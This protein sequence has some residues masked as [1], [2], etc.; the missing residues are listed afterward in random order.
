MLALDTNTIICFFKAQGRVAQRLAQANPDDLAIP[1]VVLYELEVGIAKST[2]PETRRARVD[3]LV[4]LVHLLPFGREE[5]RIAARVRASL[6]ASGRPLGPIDTM[7]AGTALYHTATLV[8][9][10]TDEFARVPGL[11]IVD[12]Y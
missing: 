8:T 1:L 10:N 2:A 3:E 9:H 7:I 6:E 4:S 11:Q 5:A 12:W